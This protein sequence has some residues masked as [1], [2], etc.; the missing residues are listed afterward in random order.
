MAFRQL[1]GRMIDQHSLSGE[2]SIEQDEAASRPRQATSTEGEV[3]SQ[4]VLIGDQ[5]ASAATAPPSRP[6]TGVEKLAIIS[7]QVPKRA[8]S[9]TTMVLPKQPGYCCLEIRDME[10]GHLFFYSA[11]LHRGAQTEGMLFSLN[12]RWLPGVLEYYPAMDSR[13]RRCLQGQV[14][15]STYRGSGE[16]KELAVVAQFL[17]RDRLQQYAASIKSYTRDESV[18]QRHN[19]VT[20]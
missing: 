18:V 1:D 10:S 7:C 3:G 14:H 13:H 11:A 17:G 8:A 5:V 9:A 2:I 19:H 15:I 6:R 20:E 16:V 4:D 12:F